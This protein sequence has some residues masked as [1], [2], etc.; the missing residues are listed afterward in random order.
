MAR[1]PK[2][3][4]PFFFGNVLSERNCEFRLKT[5]ANATIPINSVLH[6]VSSRLFQGLLNDDRFGEEA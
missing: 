3:G 5:L 6:K 2:T 4:C 1:Q